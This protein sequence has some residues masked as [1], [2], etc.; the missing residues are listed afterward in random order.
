MAG[1]GSGKAGFGARVSSSKAAA[2]VAVAFVALL[3]ICAGI[4]FAATDGGVE[5]DE[6]T[7]LSAPPSDQEGV[8]LIA[9]RS[10]TSE[11]FLLPRRRTRSPDLRVAHSLPRYRRRLAADRGRTGRSRRCRPGKR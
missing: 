7:A 10:A 4:A 6:S 11:T 1:V 5:H 3:M 8:E 9:E 2:V